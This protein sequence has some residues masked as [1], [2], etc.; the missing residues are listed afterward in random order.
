MTDSPPLEYSTHE[1]A[2]PWSH[3]QQD[4]RCNKRRQRDPRPKQRRQWQP[5]EE[6]SR[7]SCPACFPVAIDR[8]QTPIMGTHHAA[9]GPAFVTIESPTGLRHNSPMVC[10]KYKP[11][12]HPRTH[13]G[14]PCLLR[15]FR[16]R[17]DEGRIPGPRRSVPRPRTSRD[18][19]AAVAPS[20]ST[21]TPK[22]GASPKIMNIEFSD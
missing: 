5:I 6:S 11:T 9:G 16:G 7:K 12:S 20:G 2:N 14:T 4:E 19:T 8:N 21:A 18:S 10:R 1:F 3:H 15:D 22:S 17:D 13:P